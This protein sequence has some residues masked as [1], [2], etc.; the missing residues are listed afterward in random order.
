MHGLLKAVWLNRPHNAGTSLGRAFALV[1]LAVTTPSVRGQASPPPE[2]GNAS[3]S[4][5]GAETLPSVPVAAIQAHLNLIRQVEP[6]YPQVAKSAHVSGTVVLHCIIGKDGTVRYVQYVSGPPLLMKSAMDAVRQW[7]YQ[8]TI[9]NGKNVQVETSVPVVF[10]LGGSSAPDTSQVIGSRPVDRYKR[11]GY[12]N[13][14]AGVID[15]K[16]KSRLASI[17]KDLEEK[18]KIRMDMVTIESLEGQSA[19]DFATDLANLWCVSCKETN[20][21][22]LILIAVEDRQWRISVSRSLE[23]TMPDEDAARL[24]REMLPLLK[25]AEYGKALLQL[26]KRIQSEMPQKVD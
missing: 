25:N 5:S 18:T 6:V 12:V 10:T 15:S 19:K 17:S 11:S 4:S 14:F 13:D 2:T 22:L 9:I 8:P 16:D 20:G 24:G 26:A 23:S 1:M 7:K 21:V 3:Q